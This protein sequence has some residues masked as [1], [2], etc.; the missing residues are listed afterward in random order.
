MTRKPKY[1]RTIFLPIL[2]LLMCIPAMAQDERTE[3]L[4]IEQLNDLDIVLDIGPGNQ[5]RLQQLGNSNEAY[6]RQVADYGSGIRTVQ[7]GNMNYINV[8]QSGSVYLSI[9]QKGDNN[10]YR[11]SLA[12]ED[13]LTTIEQRGSRNTIL[14]RINGNDL[15]FELIQNGQGNV[16]EQ[17]QSGTNSLSYK[18]TQS[19]ADMRVIIRSY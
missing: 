7:D 10:E 18:I 1:I 13:I 3:D 8:L 9:Y 19:G 2:S 4:V 11:A 17:Y 15:G 5:A 16:I 14:Q 6:I 12:G